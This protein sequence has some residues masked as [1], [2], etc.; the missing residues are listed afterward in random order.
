MLLA[1]LFATVLAVVTLPEGYEN[2]AYVESTGAQYIDT[3]VTPDSTTVVTLD[4]LSCKVSGVDFQVPLGTK[5]ADSTAKQMSVLIG[6]QNNMQGSVLCANWV[7]PTLWDVGARHRVVLDAVAKTIY[8]DG[9]KQTDVTPAVDSLPSIYLFARHSPSAGAESFAHG[10][11]YGC[12]I[13]KGGLLVRQYVPAYEQASGK[14]GLY[15]LVNGHFA[16]NDGTGDDFQQ[17]PLKVSQS[18]V[19]YREYLESDGTGYIDTGFFPSANTRALVD[20]LSYKKAGASFQVPFGVKNPVEDRTPGFGFSIAGD[21]SLNTAPL[22]NFAPTVYTWQEGDRHELGLDAE[23]MESYVDF[24]KLNFSSLPHSGVNFGYDSIYLFARN[25]GTGQAEALATG[26]LYGCKIFTDGVLEREFV[27]ARHK[28]GLLG[29]YER[30]SGLFYFNG[31]RQGAFKVGEPWAYGFRQVEYIESHGTE[32]VNTGVTPTSK[33]DVEFKWMSL[34]ELNEPYQ[35]LFGSR[36]GSGGVNYGFYIGTPNTCTGVMAGEAKT[37]EGVLWNKDECKTVALNG[38]T[39][40]I[41]IDGMVK[42]SDIAIAALPAVPIYLFARDTQVVAGKNEA[43]NPAVGRLYSAKIRQG[44]K[45]VRDFIPVVRKGDKKAMLYDKVWCTYFENQ[46]DGEFTA[47]P[48]R[49]LVI[50]FGSCHLL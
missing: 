44:G 1:S 19:E 27:P 46:G 41:C 31:S 16:T 11:C 14:C 47:P 17:T 38:S 7:S 29:L 9:E 33:T 8:L 37:P 28:S 43:T 6:T 13:S 20:W 50:F 10:R 3:G 42:A 15:D 26:R 5:N 23:V 24:S 18:D 2:V 36:E 32:Y 35:Y 25:A 34:K 39:K 40:E 45:L 22:C 12:T 4:W 30:I 48:P 49:G 21:N